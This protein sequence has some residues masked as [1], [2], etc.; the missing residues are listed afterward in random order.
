M[1]RLG[2]VLTAFVALVLSLSG[3]AQAGGSKPPPVKYPVILGHGLGG[4]DELFGVVD[5]FWGIPGAL[6]DEGHTVFITEVP[7]FNS[8]QVRGDIL[9]DQIEEIRAITGKSKVNLIGHSMGGLDAR[10]AAHVLGSSKIASVTTMGTPHRG[11]PGPDILMM[12]INGIDVGGLTS[13]IVNALADVFG[14]YV[15]NGN[16]NLPQDAIAAITNLTTSYLYNWNK[17]FTNAPGVYYQSY[18]GAS[19]YSISLDPLDAVMW[20]LSLLFGFERNDGLVGVNSAGWGNVRNLYLDANHM[21]EVNQ[22]FGSTGLLGLNAK[23]LYKDIV[24]DLQKRGY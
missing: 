17:Q 20:T 1:R 4:F 2:V 3:T 9:I 11:A 18:S 8:I 16:P 12:V 5:Y 21:D 22:L 7:S 14:G 10:Y 19:V 15:T 24:R 23:G 13:S 6:R